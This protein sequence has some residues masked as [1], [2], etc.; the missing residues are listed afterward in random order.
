MRIMKNFGRSFFGR[1]L[2]TALLMSVPALVPEVKAEQ[3]R[4]RGEIR[5]VDLTNHSLS[6]HTR[7][8]ATVGL[9]T[10]DTTEILRHGEPDRLSDLQPGDGVEAGDDTD[11]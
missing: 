7:R 6:I 11:T 9:H 2:V 4:V 3:A 5:A 8:N 10:D 1:L